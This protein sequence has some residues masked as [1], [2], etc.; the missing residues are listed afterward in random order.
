M[1]QSI[2][3]VL[4]SL[5]PS[6]LPSPRHVPG[7]S[8]ASSRL[9]FH[10]PVFSKEEMKFTKFKTVNFRTVSFGSGRIILADLIF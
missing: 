9:Q 8:F 7:F 4:D 6:L 3:R 5:T 10:T 1:E 2:I